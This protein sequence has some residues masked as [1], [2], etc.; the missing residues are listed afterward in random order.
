MEKI[1]SKKLGEIF[2][3]MGFI[4]QAQLEQALKAQEK[5]GGYLGEILLNS[6]LIKEEN[7]AYAITLQFG[8]DFPFF[9]LRKYDINPELIK[10]VPVE[11]VERYRVIPVDK[12]RDVLSI[13]IFSPDNLDE[14][15]EKI[16]SMTDFK[17][18]EVFLTTNRQINEAIAK[19]YYAR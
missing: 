1:T 14:V 18:V 7:L 3:E 12:F 16:Y 5:T 8:Q 9:N 19:H 13:A 4:D 17:L 2:L 10:L 15:L 11:F 6:G